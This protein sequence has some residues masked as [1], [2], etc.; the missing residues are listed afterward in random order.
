MLLSHWPF[1]GLQ[2]T[3][4]SIC[5]INKRSRL[6]TLQMYVLWCAYEGRKR[7]FSSNKRTSSKW[8]SSTSHIL[9]K[10][11][12]FE[13]LF[14]EEE[15]D[16]R[17]HSSALWSKWWSDWLIAKQILQHRLLRHRKRQFSQ[18]RNFCRIIG[19]WEER[20]SREY[21]SR[22]ESYGPK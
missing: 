5:Q 10:Q 13:K 9:S 18:G 7:I 2:G 22:D 19:R 1:R 20:E 3:V 16:W 12:S 8:P 17:W 15:R 14:E 11:F 21:F 6:T 4:H